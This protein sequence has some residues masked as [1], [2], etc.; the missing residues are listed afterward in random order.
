MKRKTTNKM[1]KKGSRKQIDEQ[2]ERKSLFVVKERGK[3]NREK[4]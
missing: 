4:G 3:E 1:I 2:E